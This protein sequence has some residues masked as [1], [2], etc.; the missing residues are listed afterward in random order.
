M[1]SI[2]LAVHILF[3]TIA[4]LSGFVALIPRKGGRWHILIGKVFFISMIGMAGAASLLAIFSVQEEINAAI[5]L[6][7]IYLLLTAR[8]AASNR[9]GIVGPKEKISALAGALILIAFTFLSIDAYQSRK[10][11]IDGVYVE[12]FYVY[13]IISALAFALDLRVLIKGKLIGRQRIA[14][15]VWR[16]VLALFIASGSLFL[17]QPQVFPEAIRTSGALNVP[18]L[19]VVLVLFFWLIRVYIGRRFSY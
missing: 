18:V 7:T 12:A 10:T 2:V 9:K 11:A 5:G 15:H 4:I 13:T 6:F 16:M 14:R 8:F 17:G 3:G 1:N 19:L